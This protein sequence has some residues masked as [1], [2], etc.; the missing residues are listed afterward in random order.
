MLRLLEF[1]SDVASR[2][3][4]AILKMKRKWAGA[5]QEQGVLGKTELAEVVGEEKVAELFHRFG[6]R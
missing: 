2:Q 5:N 1:R 6:D 3:L 4:A